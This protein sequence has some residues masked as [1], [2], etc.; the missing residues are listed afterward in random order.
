MAKVIER[1]D[2]P[3]EKPAEHRC[4]HCR[5]LVE[6]ERK[7]IQADARDGDYVVCPVCGKFIG[8]SRVFA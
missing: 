6:Y 8:A 3:S 7:D 2:V 4:Y 1:G 5:S